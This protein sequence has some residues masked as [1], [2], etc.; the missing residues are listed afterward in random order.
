MSQPVLSKTHSQP[1]TAGH[2]RY[3]W[4]TYSTVILLAIASAAGVFYPAI[5]ERDAVSWAV[6][7]QG[8]DFAN[9]VLVVPALLISGLLAMRGSR[10]AE[11]V[12]LG[13]MFYVAY[14]Y[15]VYAF[16]LTFNRLFLVYVAVLGCSVYGLIYGLAAGESTSLARA[17]QGKRSV[18]ATRIML[19]ISVMLFYLLWLRD[20]VP[21]LIANTVPAGLLDVGLPTNPVH[22]LDIGL[23]LPAMILTVIGL[24]KGQPISYRIAPA[25]LVFVALM[26]AAI[27]SM[28]V[29]LMQAGLPG[30]PALLGVFG[31]LSGIYL[32]L[33]IWYLRDT[34]DHP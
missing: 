15:V 6:Q 13:V 23:T 11:L 33:V 34:P 18:Q 4:L 10:R 14:S 24:G 30:D 12:W 1:A 31:V 17:L 22:V 21:N 16:D 29:Y 19:G 25:L 7:G 5:Y 32:I 3:L 27:F 2:P 9:L 20:I 28:T 26:A 8:Q